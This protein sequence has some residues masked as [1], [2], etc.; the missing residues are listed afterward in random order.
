MQQICVLCNNIS[1]IDIIGARACQVFF[2]TFIRT[3]VNSDEVLKALQENLLQRWQRGVK[4]ML[5]YPAASP[6]KQRFYN[7]VLWNK[8]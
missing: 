5:S 1:D 7:R 3:F 6:N 8:S 4:K 2:S